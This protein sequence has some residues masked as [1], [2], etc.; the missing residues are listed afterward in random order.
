MIQ[1]WIGQSENSRKLPFM[2]TVH[3]NIKWHSHDHDHILIEIRDATQAHGKAVS[4]TRR[5]RSWIQFC[6]M[7][8]RRESHRTR[9]ND[10]KRQQKMY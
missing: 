8:K 9:L 5:H 6:D 7:Q 2:L 1:M 4:K 10:R 3:V